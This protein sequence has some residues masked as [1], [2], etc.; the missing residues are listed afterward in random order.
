MMDKLLAVVIPPAAIWLCRASLGRSFTRTFVTSILLWA[1]GLLP[2]MAYA[3]WI[4]SLHSPGHGVSHRQPQ[5]GRP[6]PFGSSQ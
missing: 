4:V 3:L 2:G 5:L 6:N 1:C